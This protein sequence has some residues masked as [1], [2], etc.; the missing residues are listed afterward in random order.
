MG[1]LKL[2]DISV[3]AASEDHLV[4][5]GRLRNVFTNP[6]FQWEAMIENVCSLH[7]GN[8]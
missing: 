4:G 6:I 5:P 2:K 1:S 3:D 8:R 7:C